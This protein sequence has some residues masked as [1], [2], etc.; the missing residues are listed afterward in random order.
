M[1][2]PIILS[3]IRINNILLFIGVDEIIWLTKVWFLL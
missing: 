1:V 2:E 3:I